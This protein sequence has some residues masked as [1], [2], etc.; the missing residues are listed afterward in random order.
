MAVLGSKDLVE[1]SA[2]DLIGQYVG[3]TG[4]KT[5]QKLTEALGRVLFIDEAYRFCDGHFG[6]EAVNELVD[7]L[8]KPKFMGKL[9]VIL[10]GYTDQIDELLRINPGLSSRFPEEVVFENMAPEKCLELLDREIREQDI[11]ISPAMNHV[12]PIERQQ[13]IDIIA[14]ASK[15]QSWGNGRDVKNIARS[16]C[17]DAFADSVSPVISVGIPDVVSHLKKFLESQKARNKVRKDSI[18]P[19]DFLKSLMP[20][21]RTQAPPDAPIRRTATATDVKTATSTRTDGK[22][23]EDEQDPKQT[24]QSSPQR[25]PGVSDEIWQQLQRNIAEQKALEE[26]EQAFLAMQE[27]ECQARR[28]AEEAVA[29]E[30][31]RLEDE[32]RLA[33]EKRRQE[34]EK[35]LQEEQRRIEAAMKAKKE[36]EERLRREKEELER[37]RR[38]ELAIQKKIRDMG[39]CPNGFRWVKEMG[40]YRCRGGAHFLSDAQLQI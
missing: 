22:E 13:M 35:K 33:D 29:A 18:A 1:C 11:L 32:K 3:Q 25:D 39:I 26:A 16:I 2:S 34:I 27:R 17:S 38:K 31:R 36:A 10:A 28:A 24:S 23:S 5:Q 19:D 20:P 30:I 8:T 37:K 21:A 15:L 14:E 6:K 7:C 12:S 9:V 4:P 40:G